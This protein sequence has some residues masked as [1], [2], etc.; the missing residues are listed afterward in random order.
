MFYRND[1]LAIEAGKER[2]KLQDLLKGVP[3]IG[4]DAVSAAPSDKGEGSI[5]GDEEMEEAAPKSSGYNFGMWEGV[6]IRCLL[7]IW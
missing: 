7:N 6:F 4:N 2:P 5:R 1:D 3:Q